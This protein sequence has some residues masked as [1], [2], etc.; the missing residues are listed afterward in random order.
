MGGL[1]STQ[2]ASNMI[3]HQ[4]EVSDV[5]PKEASE[6]RSR[7]GQYV[8]SKTEWTNSQMRNAIDECVSKAVNETY[9]G[10]FDAH[11]SVD[12]IHWRADWNLWEKAGGTKTLGRG[13]PY[14]NSQ[15][16]KRAAPF[17]ETYRRLHEKREHESTMSTHELQQELAQERANLAQETANLAQC[18]VDLAEEQWNSK[19][20]KRQ[21]AQ[22]K[23]DHETTKSTL[24][25]LKQE[26]RN[27]GWRF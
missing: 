8:Q 13:Y 14:I 27:L 11:V 4:P 18:R 20:I 9:E 22:E 3:S 23:A 1:Q 25:A 17:S 16:A 19:Q 15:P 10:R 12:W 6:R 2:S 21:L 5:L 26:L 24:E 7:V